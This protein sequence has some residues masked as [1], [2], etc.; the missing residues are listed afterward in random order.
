MKK[1]FAFLILLVIAGAAFYFWPDLTD[2]YNRLTK[3]VLEIEKQSIEPLVAEWQN[4]ISAPPPLIGSQQ[5]PESVLTKVGVITWT[6]FQRADNRL[7]T[8]SENAKLDGAALAKAKDMFKNQYFEHVSPTGVGP[9]DVIKTAA[10]AYISIGE[11]L[12]MGNFADDKT[13]VQAWMD[14]PGHR[15]NILNQKFSE[16][17][18]AVLKG[19]FHGQITWMA[20]QEFGLPAAACPAPSIDLKKRIE[21][22]K[23]QLASLDGMIQAKH[24]QLD[25]GEL[26][27]GDEYNLAI[28]EY[29][30]LVNRYNNLSAQTKNLV[31]NYNAQVNAYNACLK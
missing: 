23:A 10:Y 25:S 13:L 19:T 2:L 15:A 31:N 8:L 22:N 17:G 6:N 7:A 14:S 24:N 21:E 30:I 28:T 29:N 3:Q 18:V 1:L 9:A 16:I 27:R 4:Q 11:N 12:A 26:A 20:V 5:A